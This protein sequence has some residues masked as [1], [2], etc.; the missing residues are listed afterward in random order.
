MFRRPG[1]QLLTAREQLSEEDPKFFHASS[2]REVST[3][4]E[5]SIVDVKWM[6]RFKEWQLI[7]QTPL[8]PETKKMCARSLYALNID[9]I[10]QAM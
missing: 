9:T 1:R 8:S 6:L 2:V 4:I 7:P 10:V 5:H 3:R